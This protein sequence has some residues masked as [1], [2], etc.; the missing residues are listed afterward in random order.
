MATVRTTSDCLGR[1]RASVAKVARLSILRHALFHTLT[2][3]SFISYSSGVSGVQ[4]SYT[5]HAGHHLP[6]AFFLAC[7]ALVRHILIDDEKLPL[8]PPGCRLHSNQI[9]FSYRSGQGKN[10]IKKNR[11]RGQFF[12]F[13]FILKGEGNF[14]YIPQKN[15]E[16]FFHS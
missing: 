6:T 8:Q 16:F 7:L 10:D 4:G 11:P 9:C 15:I 13:I 1:S 5:T 12:W 3:C 2:F 14:K